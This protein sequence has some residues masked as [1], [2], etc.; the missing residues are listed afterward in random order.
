MVYLAARLLRGKANYTQTFRAYSFG[1]TIYAFAIFALIPGLE[2]II[3]LVVVIGAVI[4]IW[5]AV[6]EA[7]RIL[8]WRTLVLP[9]LTIIML[10]IVSA[11][12]GLFVAGTEMSIN[13]LMNAFGLTP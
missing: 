13:A 6:S 7:H 2:Q 1:N 12:I 5:V 10:V 3:R 9:F 8:G 11:A 4:A